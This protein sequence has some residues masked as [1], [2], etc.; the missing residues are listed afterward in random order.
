MNCLYLHIGQPKT[1]TSALQV[2][3]AQNRSKLKKDNIFYP[4]SKFDKKAS[5]GGVTSGNGIELAKFLNDRIHFKFNSSNYATN[6]NDLLKSSYNKNIVFSSEYLNFN[7]EEKVDIFKS[8]CKENNFKIKI[9]IFVR[10]PLDATF[11]AY[12]QAIKSIGYAY[13]FEDFIETYDYREK[14]VFQSIEKFGKENCILLNYDKNK[15]HLI[16]SLLNIFELEYKY[17]YFNF[18]EN[19]VNKSLSQSEILLFKEFNKNFINI[20][21][22]NF[23]NNFFANIKN[24]EVNEE[25]V[26]INCDTYLKLQDRF[27]E[28]LLKLNSIAPNLELTFA[29]SKF[30]KGNTTSNE[31]FQINR[32]LIAMLSKV[33]Q[34]NLNVK[35]EIKSGIYN[36]TKEKISGWAWE[37]GNSAPSNILVYINDKLIG[38][39]LANK[40]DKRLNR[41]R[42]GL[43]NTKFVF[44]F[45]K[46][47]DKS[48]LQNVIVYIKT[49]TGELI[50][51]ENIT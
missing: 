31:N 28:V 7:N 18:N 27:T 25:E 26:T 14:V 47:L 29:T 40:F 50:K 34:E 21:Q 42:I 36:L 12:S 48:D 44:L 10:N 5:V 38:K 20:K 46:Q 39:G 33:L 19:R 17:D 16:K 32:H 49:K 1:G 4:E 30:K 15:Q 43:G 41:K 9:I 35:Q 24:D 22:T 13:E 23:I 8:I 2:F 11:A 3:F 37:R 6:F 45:D 51:I